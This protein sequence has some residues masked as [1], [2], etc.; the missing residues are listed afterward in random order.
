[1]IIYNCILTFLSTAFGIVF[2][3]ILVWLISYYIIK[4]Y[5]DKFWKA[6]VSNPE[7]KDFYEKVKK[8]IEKEV[9]K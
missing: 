1:M 9:R 4:N 2:G 8:I 3:T 7:I 6:L 5:A